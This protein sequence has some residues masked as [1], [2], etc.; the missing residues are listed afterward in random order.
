MNVSHNCAHVHVSY[1]DTD[2]IKTKH[3]CLLWFTSDSSGETMYIPAS[4]FSLKPHIRTILFKWGKRLVLWM[5]G[6]ENW[7]CGNEEGI[8]WCR[9][10]SVFAE[11]LIYA[12]GKSEGQLIEEMKVF[13]WAVNVMSHYSVRQLAILGFK[14]LMEKKNY[15]CMCGY[16]LYRF[17]NEKWVLRSGGQIRMM[18]YND[19]LWLPFWSACVFPNQPLVL[20]PHLFNA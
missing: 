18:L 5:N 8:D 6:M 14:R 7:V 19:L 4:S 1:F 15:R 16:M 9:S 2:R 13:L 11:A 3:T 17:S 20:K 10:S 12:W